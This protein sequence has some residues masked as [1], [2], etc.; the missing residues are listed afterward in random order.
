MLTACTPDK[1]ESVVHRR[2]FSKNVFEEEFASLEIGCDTTNQLVLLKNTKWLKIHA[3]EESNQENEV[4]PF[5]MNKAL[6][7]T[8]RSYE[9]ELHLERIQNGAFMFRYTGVQNIVDTVQAID[10]EKG[11]TEKSLADPNKIFNVKSKVYYEL[12]SLDLAYLDNAAKQNPDKL[13][14]HILTLYRNNKTIDK[15]RVI[16]KCDYFK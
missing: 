3:P 12:D 10:F 13:P 15:G 7:V 14:A 4:F 9:H 16:C 8:E 5:K 2:N 6:K 11:V 1:T